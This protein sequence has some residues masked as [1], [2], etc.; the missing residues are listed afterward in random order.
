M[1]PK[2]REAIELDRLHITTLYKKRFLLFDTLG[3]NRI[4][5]YA[6]DYQ[7]E[8]LFKS[9]RWHADGT[10]K[11]APELFAQLYLIHGWY[12]GEMHPCAFIFM[13]DRTKPTYKKMLRK[14]KESSAQI[15]QPSSVFV[16]FEQ[17]AI[18]AF[19]EEFP[20]VEVKGCHFHFTQCIWRKIQELGLSVEY[21]ENKQ[22]RVWLEYFKTLA[23]IPLNLV[24]STF[25]YL[26]S[27][28]PQSEHT[29]KI[30]SFIN[31]FQSTFSSLINFC[32]LPHV[33]TLFTVF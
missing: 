12:M 28:Q 2:T 24:D 8:I 6:S 14:L 18:K 10:F 20:V 23:F 25:L 5:A 3:E 7:L 16:D 4:I 30:K 32:D 22:T 13:P 15:L 26:L 1:L 33:Q 27:I 9:I 17:G 29:D 19:R 21:K 31:Y 11:S